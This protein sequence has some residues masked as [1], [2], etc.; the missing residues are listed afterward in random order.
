[1]STVNI[2]RQKM[3]K[4]IWCEGCG[5]GNLQDILTQVL[6]KHV[7]KN[8]GV[9]PARPEGLERIKNHIAMVSG[10]GCT[11][12]LPG[13]LDL[14]TLHTTHGRSLAFATGLKMARPALT[15]VLA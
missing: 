10:I 11:S 12:R 3:R 5:L 14:N 13:H 7:A 1:M 4:S 2:Y 6:V 9:D 8:L 15:V